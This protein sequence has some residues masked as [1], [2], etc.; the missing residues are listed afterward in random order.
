MLPWEYHRAPIAR[1]A[2]LP[3]GIRMPSDLKVITR[4]SAAAKSISRPVPISVLRACP[5]NGVGEGAGLC[6][7][8]SWDGSLPGPEAKGTTSDMALLS[9]YMPASSSGIPAAM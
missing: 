1:S 8:A 3:T 5:C 6:T 2:F 9:R 7:G 4:F